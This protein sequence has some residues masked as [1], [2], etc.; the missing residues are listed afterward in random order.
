MRNL[1]ISTGYYLLDEYIKVD[2]KIDCLIIGNK[3]DFPK[4]IQTNSRIFFCNSFQTT[5]I[6]NTI[7]QLE[8]KYDTVITL[9]DKLVITLEELSKLIGIHIIQ[10]QG[11]LG[12]DKMVLKNL[13]QK[14]GIAC[15]EAREFSTLQEIDSVK[16]DL[17]YP[18]I[19]KPTNSYGSNGVHKIN[20]KEDL[21]FYSRNIFKMNI[22][23]EKVYSDYLGKLMVEEYI[24]GPEYAVDII[25]DEYKP[26]LRCI[27]SRLHKKGDDKFPD[28]VYFVD[29][30]LSCDEK[31]KIFALAESV[32]KIL[33]IKNG[34]SH[35]E[36]RNRYNDYY[37]LENAI[38]PGGGGCMYQ[39]H[40]YATNVNYFEIFIKTMMQLKLHTEKQIY[41]P[42]LYYFFFSYANDKSGIVENVIFDRALIDKN[43]KIIS[44]DFLISKGTRILPSE[45]AMRYTIFI[46]GIVS[47]NTIEEFENAIEKVDR[48][49]MIE[50]EDENEKKF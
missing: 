8:K 29:P 3:K 5:D 38:R 44:V 16:E 4:D 47:A 2:Y 41:A 37:V 10:N 23:Q 24:D 34:A 7:Q 12:R 13:L 19:I 43:T 18:V 49:C 46:Y 33:K 21:V 6:A 32:G 27:S 50:M 35:T 20:N 14:N 42:N 39:L 25:W 31:D 28:Y 26:V 9:D 40:K 17:H 36:I 45:L 1:I 48:A 30:N 22:I 15:P 11:I